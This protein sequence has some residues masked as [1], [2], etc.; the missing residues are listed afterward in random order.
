MW[1]HRDV[2]AHDSTP[3]AVCAGYVHQRARPT[4]FQAAHQ[5]FCEN[6]EYLYDL[7]QVLEQSV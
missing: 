1:G 2:Q 6:I 4:E 5:L 3:T 7:M